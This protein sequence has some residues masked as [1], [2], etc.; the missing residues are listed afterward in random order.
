[1]PASKFMIPLSFSALLGMAVNLFRGVFPQNYLLISF[2]HY[3]QIFCSTGGTI[4]Y[5]GT[6]SNLTVYSLVLA[7]Y[8]NY[9]FAFFEVGKVGGPCTVFGW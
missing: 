9:S 6:S 8:P 3:L 7:Q 5:I 4:T 1:M 2:P